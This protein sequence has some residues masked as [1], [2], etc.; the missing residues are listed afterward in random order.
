MWGFWAGAHHLGANGA[1]VNLDWTL[2]AAGL[3]YLELREEWRTEVT[4]LTDTDGA[5]ALRGFH[6]TYDV[7]CTFAGEVTKLH[8]EL[9]PGLNPQ[10]LKIT[11]NGSP[12]CDDCSGDIN[13]D[14]RVDSADLG[15]LLADWGP[16]PESSLPCS[17]DLDQDLIVNAADLGLL[18]ARWGGC[19]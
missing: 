4:G 12:P 16:C 2:N 9:K 13:G 14:D 18:L 15:L 5:F 11:L 7:K 3:K 1:I 10:I 6:G 19:R 17:A 8:T